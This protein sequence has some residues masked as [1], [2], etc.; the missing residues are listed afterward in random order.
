MVTTPSSHCVVGIGGT[1]Q[2][3]TQG[4]RKRALEHG[5]AGF[6][7]KPVQGEALLETLRATLG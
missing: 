2:S 1:G 3:G 5:A 6:F 7:N 4:L